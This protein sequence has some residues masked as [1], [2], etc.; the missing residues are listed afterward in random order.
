[1]SADA[2]DA[3]VSLWRGAGPT[4]GEAARTDAHRAVV[5]A[6]AGVME[7]YCGFA[8]SLGHKAPL[9]EP[10]PLRPKGASQLVESV[11]TDL[12]D[13]CGQATATAVRVIWTGDHVDVA[14]RLQPTLAAAARGS[15]VH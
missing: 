13:G 4:H 3:V 6:A 15:A 9:P 1:M 7:W 8:A 12:V 10:V 14:R 11:R 5:G 2:S